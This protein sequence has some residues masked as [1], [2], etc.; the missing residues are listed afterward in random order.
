M[1][2]SRQTCPRS[3]GNVPFPFVMRSPRCTGSPGRGCSEPGCCCPGSTGTSDPAPC[4]LCNQLPNA[5]PSPSSDDIPPVD[6]MLLKPDD[7]PPRTAPHRGGN[8]LPP[9]LCANAKLGASAAATSTNI[10]R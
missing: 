9:L 4:A 8:E 1:S 5:L 3:F 6:G 10:R 7:C 2:Y